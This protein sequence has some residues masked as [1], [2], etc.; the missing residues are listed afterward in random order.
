MIGII[1]DIHG[2]HVALSTVLN[3]LDE[4]GVT[5]I[6]CLGDIGGYYCQI[7]ECCETLR[8]RRVFS[9]MGNHDWYLAKGEACPRSNSANDCLNY[10]RKVIFPDNLAWL[11]SLPER[12][13]VHGLDI[14]H[15]GWNDPI[16]EYVR[17]SSEYFSVLP[18]KFFASGHT[19][20]QTVWSDG[21]KTYC[22]PGSVGQPR[23][24]DPRAAFATWDGYSFHIHRIEYDID[25][26]QRKMALAG[27]TPYYSENLSKGTSIGGKISAL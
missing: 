12:S 16:D 2:N 20:V 24:G 13:Q 14:V 9:I 23:D 25:Q 22:N 17:P 15:G 26:I 10:Q 19:H 21:E 7:N 11:A 18:G 3:K 4:L 6:I 27:F 5:E 1:S 8:Q